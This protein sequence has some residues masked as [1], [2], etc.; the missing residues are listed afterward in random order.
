MTDLAGGTTAPAMRRGVA[1][2][3]PSDAAVI[4]GAFLGTRLLLTAFGLVFTP[5]FYVATRTLGER[6]GRRNRPSEQQPILLPAE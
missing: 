1:G 3:A 6:L 4:V 2:F 5:V